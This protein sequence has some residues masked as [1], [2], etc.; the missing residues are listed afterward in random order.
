[1]PPKPIAFRS[2][3][4]ILRFI[5]HSWFKL[6]TLLIIRANLDCYGKGQI[7]KQVLIRRGSLVVADVPAPE[8]SDNTILVRVAFSLISTGTETASLS[9]GGKSLLRQTYEEPAKIA[10]GLQL[11][12]QVGVR[13]AV[14]IINNEMQKARETGDS[15]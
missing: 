9:A 15:C 11:V 12:Q 6:F 1:M 2:I 3:R 10:R 4:L 5:F 7:L 8:I 14:A 13:R